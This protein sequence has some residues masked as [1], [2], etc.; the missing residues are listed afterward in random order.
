VELFFKWI[1]QPSRIKQFDGTSETA[2]KTP[3]WIAVSVHLLVAIVRRRLGPPAAL[4]TCRQVLAVTIFE[5][6]QTKSAL[7]A[8]PRRS[9]RATDDNKPTLFS[10]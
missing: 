6:M 2:V 7:L 10:H 8:A 3:I 1:K 5:K 9:K 4:D